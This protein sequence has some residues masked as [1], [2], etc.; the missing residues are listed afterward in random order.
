[1]NLFSLIRE[2]INFIRQNVSFY[3]RKKKISRRI[4]PG[5]VRHLHPDIHCKAKWYG[6]AYGGFFIHPDLLRSSSIIYSFGIGKD[7]T[8]D[9]KCIHKHQCQIFAFDPTPKTIEWLKTRKLSPNF[10]FF[11][12]GI[13]EKAAGQY[14]FFL[15]RNP[16]AVSGSLMHQDLVDMDNAVQVTMKPMADIM[17]ELGHQHIDVVKMDIEGSEYAVLDNILNANISIDQILIEF[18]D[19]LFDVRSPKSKEIVEKLR[20]AGYGL[21]AHSSSYEEISFIKRSLIGK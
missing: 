2:K 4:A 19:R 5:F 8:F 16:K 7:I 11:P 21:F 17:H 3:F 14:S 1:M 13:T 9:T 6:S 12:Y 18:H 10:K 15:P 20:A